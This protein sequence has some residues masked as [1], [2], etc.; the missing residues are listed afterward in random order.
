MQFFTM[1]DKPKQEEQSAASV[2]IGFLTINCL[3][4]GI[5]ASTL[6]LLVGSLRD[7]RIALYV[8][9]PYLTYTLFLRRD[10]LKDGRHWH[11]FSKNNFILKIFRQ[12][13]R[14]EIQKPIPPEIL[15]LDSKPSAQVILG[16]FP[17]G[18]YAD[19]RVVM[20][21]LLGDAMPNMALKCRSLAGKSHAVLR[22]TINNNHF[23]FLTTE[24]NVP[25]MLIIFFYLKKSFIHVQNPHC[26]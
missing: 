16:V 14:M 22:E 13:L 3:F 6:L 26:S 9:L 11:E 17:H 7:T 10:E 1:A 12:Y 15:S 5:V 21:G 18:S 4:G 8:T 25:S 24:R 23:C 20:D 19:F 2:A